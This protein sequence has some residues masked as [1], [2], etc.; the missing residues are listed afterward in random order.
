M[1]LTIEKLV[2]GGE[3]L[4]RLPAD[5]HGKGKAV[6]VPFVLEG[7]QVEAELA[8]QKPGFA[9]AALQQVLAPSPDRMEPGCPY[10]LRCGGCHYQHAGYAHQL[11]A[12]A[13]IL[14]ETLRR[15]AKL[16]FAGDLQVHSAEP[17]GYRNRTRMKIA[18]PFRMGYYRLG[19][20]ELL[21]VERCPISSP[22]INRAI[23]ALWELGRAGQTPPA[24]REV[25]FFAGA[26]GSALLVSFFLPGEPPAPRA[27][28]SFADALRAALPEAAGVLFFQQRAGGPQQEWGK[29]RTPSDDL[30]QPSDARPIASFGDSA[31]EYRTARATYRVS[32]GAFFQTN[33][34]LVDE[35]VAAVTEHRSGSTALDLFA[36]VGLFA[37]VLAHGFDRVTAVEASPLSFADLRHNLPPHVKAVEQRTETF[38][39]RHRGRADLVVVDPPRS[40]LGGALARDLAN[41]AA[42]RVTYVSCNPATLARD[43]R[44]LVA[45]GYRVEAAHLFDLFPQT[46]HIESVF[47]LAR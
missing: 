5:E 42:P 26:D 22:L 12:K 1:R 10:F 41:L 46:Y 6:F 16:E 19:S 11:A 14:G 33:R 2:Y 36:G 34:F 4:A 47:H 31:L 32:G 39:Q 35:L 38:V 13:A 9:R 8:E 24:A 43:L 21:D 28:E 3:G 30:D 23:A 45:G 27:L 40:G 17:W 20:H 29:V 44:V 18:Q 25:E 15:T 7:E 37:A